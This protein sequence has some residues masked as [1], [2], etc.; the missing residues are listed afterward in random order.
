MVT[1]FRHVNGLSESSYLVAARYQ[2][3]TP[4]CKAEF[5]ATNQEW[6]NECLTLEVKLSLGIVITKSN[7]YSQ[8]FM[9]LVVDLQQSA[10]VACAAEMIAKARTATYVTK[11]LQ[12]LLA[13][14]RLKKQ[15]DQS[16]QFGDFFDHC[17]GYNG[18]LGPG[19]DTLREL[20]M[21][22]HAADRPIHNCCMAGVTAKVCAPCVCMRRVF[23]FVF[24]FGFV[25][26]LFSFFVL[27]FVLCFVL[28]FV[29]FFVWFGCLVVCLCVCV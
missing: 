14:A 21:Q 22:S 18:T 17:D 28:F 2:C 9:N 10:T 4:G 8:E 20:V 5:L 3:Q 29:L 11:K 16:H 25:L 27:C 26:F 23:C 19:E 1:Y 15:T 12:Y 24:C 6:W 13:V 7:A